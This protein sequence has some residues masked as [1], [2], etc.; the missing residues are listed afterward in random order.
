M[1]AP[2]LI[3]SGHRP[4]RIL[5]FITSRPAFEISFPI[6]E[7]VHLRGRVA[8]HLVL[9]SRLR[10]RDPRYGQVVRASGISA[11]WQ[12]I[13]RIEVLGL[14]S[15]WMADAIYAHVDP[16]AQFKKARLRDR[17]LKASGCPLFYIQHGMIQW[18]V[19]RP[20][21]GEL[22]YHADRI[23]LW[24]DPGPDILSQT[25]TPEARANVR[26]VGFVKSNPL[27]PHP[28]T[29]KVRADL[30]G[31]RRRVLIC[32]KFGQE[33]LRFSAEM[34]ANAYAWVGDLADRNKDT[35]FILRGHR[36]R[37]HAQ[38]DALD[39]QIEKAHPNVLI[40]KQGRGMLGSTHMHDVMEVCDMVIT[41]PSTVVLDA[42]YEDRPVAVL[43]N[44][45]DLLSGLPN[46][47]SSD[48]LEAFLDDPAQ[49]NSGMAALRSDYGEVD[50]NLD[51]AADV[52]E[53]RMLEG[54]E[55]LL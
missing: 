36:G 44:T 46:I 48:E 27:T 40:S 21:K 30:S 34:L 52:I 16:M 41:H 54:R 47:H 9:R 37:G 35:F 43:N 4:P 11:S 10:D 1:T 29:E 8:P 14:A 32:H 28:D 12:T 25:M 18:G 22:E 17:A 19:N 5:T 39:D 49:A 24:T 45:D 7:R 13:G 3:R 38:R 6:L 50:A 53:E 42:I 51:R 31:Y 15:Y 23:M 33:K 26:E 55:D 2:F 20:K